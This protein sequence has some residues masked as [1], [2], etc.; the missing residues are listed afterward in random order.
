MKYTIIIFLLVGLTSLTNAQSKTR[1]CLIARDEVGATVSTPTIKFVPTKHSPS[2]IKY[3]FI[4]DSDGQ[5]D[6]KVM[7]GIYDIEVKAETYYK[8]VLRRQLL[9]YDPQGCIIVTLKTKIQPHQ[10]I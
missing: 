9:K 2:R 7:D 6:I 8:V 3:N 10:I 1:Y 4:G 5:I